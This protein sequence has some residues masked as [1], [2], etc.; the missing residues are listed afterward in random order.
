LT[1]PIILKKTQYILNPNKLRLI[2]M[3][4]E[5]ITFVLWH[6]HISTWKVWCDDT[7]INVATLTS[8]NQAEFDL[9]S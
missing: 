7:E 8:Q 3:W 2:Y 4:H 5:V 6:W 1:L 9:W